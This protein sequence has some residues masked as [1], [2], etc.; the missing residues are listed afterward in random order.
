MTDKKCSFCSSEDEARKYLV[1]DDGVATVCSNC[2]LMFAQYMLDQRENE[3]S[4]SEDN[5]GHEKD[6]VDK[7]EAFYYYLVQL[8]E[9]WMEKNVI[10]SYILQCGGVINEVHFRFEDEW[11]E[12][13]FVC[14]LEVEGIDSVPA[15]VEQKILN[16][17]E[18][19]FDEIRDELEEQGLDLESSLG[20]KLVLTRVD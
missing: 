16:E 3:S 10:N 6:N 5:Q 4:D 19:A 17:I 7:N 18:W 2:A 20:E 13:Y 11:D 1:S 15:N 14:E 12:Y 9:K 8:E